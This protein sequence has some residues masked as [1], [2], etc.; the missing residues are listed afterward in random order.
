[1]NKKMIVLLTCAAMSASAMTGCASSNAGASG[2]GN[3]AA[4][5]DGSGKVTIKVLDNYGGM[6]EEMISVYE[7]LNP[8]VNIE[9]E[10]VPSDSYYSK[11]T[12]LN[13]QLP[14]HRG[15]GAERP[16]GGPD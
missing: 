14:V 1:M 16:A 11:F 15:P 3:T 4:A 7:K 6:V 8:E 13:D 9:Y 10:Y 12:A 2:E 5:G